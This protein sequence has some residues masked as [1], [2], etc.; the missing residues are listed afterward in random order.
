MDCISVVARNRECVV[1]TC[2]GVRHRAYL[3]TVP[4]FCYHILSWQWSPPWEPLPFLYEVAMRIASTV[5]N[6]SAPR[7]P[8]GIP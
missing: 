7:R 6:A 4:G 2:L 5:A 1:Y 8:E 3:D